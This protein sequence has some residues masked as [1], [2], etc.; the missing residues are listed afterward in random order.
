MSDNIVSIDFGEKS[1]EPLP[2]RNHCMASVG[3]YFII[4][5]GSFIQY[6]TKYK[7]L[8]IYN[9]VTSIWKRY[10]APIEEQYAYMF[11]SMCAFENRV[12]IFGGSYDTYGIKKTNSLISFDICDATWQTVSPHIKDYDD[13]TPPPMIESCIFYHNGSLYI[14]GGIH[15]DGFVDSMYKFCLETSTWTLVQQNGQKPCTS[16]QIYGTVFNNQFFTFGYSEELG[17]NRFKNITIFDL[18]SNTWTTRG[19]NSKSQLYPDGL[20]TQESIAFYSRFAYVSGGEYADGYYSD[21]WRIDLETLEWL[22]LDTTLKP[23]MSYLNTFVVDDSYL[24]CF[25]G[26]SQNS[27]G[28]ITLE[29]YQIVPP[30]SDDACLESIK[31]PTRLKN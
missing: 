14:L 11:C 24:Y 2:R 4:Y 30:K 23:D 3:K 10:L 31:Q 27:D 6:F 26:T 25:G 29:C 13:N 21:V 7:E 28:F 22:K 12:F 16:S 9:T 19:T 20:R 1:T 17:R 15:S 18:N 8:W 5:G